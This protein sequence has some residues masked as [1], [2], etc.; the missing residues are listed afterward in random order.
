MASDPKNVLARVHGMILIALEDSSP[1]VVGW[2]P[3]HLTLKDLDFQLAVKSDGSLVNERGLQGNKLA[4]EL[5]KRGVEFHRVAS[6][7]VKNWRAKIEEVKNRAMWMGT[8]TVEANGFAS[9][10]FKDSEASR[11]KADAAQRARSNAKNGEDGRRRRV[12]LA[13]SWLSQ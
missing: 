8:A 2:M 7:D 12:P 13:E 10:P 9:F 3:S 4:D 1:K 5:A 6:S 11:W